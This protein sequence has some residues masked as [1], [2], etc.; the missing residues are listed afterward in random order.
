MR[1]I[2]LTQGCVL[3]PLLSNLLLDDTI[4]KHKTAMKKFHVGYWNM[5]KILISEI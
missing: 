2:D 1:I 4:K 5:E 3:S